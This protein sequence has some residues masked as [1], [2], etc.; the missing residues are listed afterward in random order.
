MATIKLKGS[1]KLYEVHRISATRIFEA[2]KDD[3]VPGTQKLFLNDL[4][5]EKSSIDYLDLDTEPGGA[6]TQPDRYADLKRPTT[7]KEYA[8][9]TSA[10]EQGRKELE[11][12][13]LLKEKVIAHP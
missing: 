11:A 5:F 2:W 7:D 10:L 6:G 13:G 3:K 9:R 4:G 12:K 1:K 8:A